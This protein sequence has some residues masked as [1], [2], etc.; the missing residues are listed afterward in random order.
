M[1]FGWFDIIGNTGVILIITAY[2]LLQ[3]KLV[4]SA[5]I[6]YSAIN[7]LG[8][9]LIL[10][11]LTEAFNLAAFILEFFW[12]LISLWGLASALRLKRSN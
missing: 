11:S 10:F 6:S 9:S 8:A 12:I 3:A 7:A 1:E 5:S 4:D 2:F